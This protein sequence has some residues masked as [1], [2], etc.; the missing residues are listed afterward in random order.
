MS[1]IVFGIDFGGVIT[2]TDKKSTQDT[3]FKGDHLKTKA[4]E[5]AFEGVKRLVNMCGA[6]NVYI[7]SKAY[8]NTQRKTLEWLEHHD[9]YGKTGLHPDHVYFCLERREKAGI[10]KQLGINHFVDDRF[11]CIEHMEMP[12]KNKFLFNHMVLK[13]RMEQPT[14]VNN[15]KEL[16]SHF[17]DVPEHKSAPLFSYDDFPPL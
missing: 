5:G 6:S 10:C 3:F 4:L 16:I 17:V 9:F 1:K 13:H 7:V 12:W 11:D 15:W 2:S 8:P 14:Y